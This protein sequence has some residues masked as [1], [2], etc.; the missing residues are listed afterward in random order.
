MRALVFQTKWSIVLALAAVSACTSSAGDNESNEVNV[1]EAN[2]VTATVAAPENV[3]SPVTAS[4]AAN[5]AA[6]EPAKAAAEHYEASGYEPV[7]TL[8]IAKGRLDYH[9]NYGEKPI[10]VARPEPDLLKNGRRYAT[11]RLTVTITYARC[12]DAPDGYYEHQV[13]IVADGETYKGCGG[14]KTGEDE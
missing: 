2:S 3:T 14:K 12:E 6:A 1:V 10:D 7:W 5:V 4:P 9:G 13:T 8:T 11:R